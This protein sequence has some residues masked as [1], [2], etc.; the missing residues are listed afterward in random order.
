MTVVACASA[1][2]RYTVKPTDRLPVPG[3]TKAALLADTPSAGVTAPPLTPA[4]VV[5]I[6]CCVTFW[7]PTTTLGSPV[8]IKSSAAA[9]CNCGSVI[10]AWIAACKPCCC[11]AVGKSAKLSASD[12]N[13]RSVNVDVLCP[14]P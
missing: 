14:A 12:G 5:V 9:C 7:P 1:V 4:A 8:T 11:R 3:S 10:P 13:A 2:V 6:P